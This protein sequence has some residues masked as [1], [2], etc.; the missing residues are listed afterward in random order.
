MRMLFPLR[1]IAEIS[2]NQGKAPAQIIP[3]GA[4]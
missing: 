1:F 3:I 4:A 2:S